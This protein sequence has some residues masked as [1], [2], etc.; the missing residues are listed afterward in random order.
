MTE[1]FEKFS[2]EKK[3]FFTQKQ[4]FIFLIYN[5]FIQINKISQN[6]PLKCSGITD[7]QSMHGI[8][9]H[10]RKQRKLSKLLGLYYKDLYVNLTRYLLYKYGTIH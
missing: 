4:D 3:H 1:S 8:P 2:M 6:Q 7:T 5:K 9:F 10:S